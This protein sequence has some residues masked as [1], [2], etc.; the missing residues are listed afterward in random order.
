MPADFSARVHSDFHGHELREYPLTTELHGAL[1]W[2]QYPFPIRDSDGADCTVRNRKKN[3]WDS[4]NCT[5]CTLVHS[6][7]PSVTDGPA[8]FPG[9]QRERNAWQTRPR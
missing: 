9:R 7:S 4:S 5:F 1:R 3:Q 8:D 6:E 2:P